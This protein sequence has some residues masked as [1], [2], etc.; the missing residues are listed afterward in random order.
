MIFSSVAFSVLWP[1]AN[2]ALFLARWFPVV[3]VF[4]VKGM[5][6]KALRFLTVDSAPK[7]LLAGYGLYMVGIAADMHTAFMVKVQ[8]WRN[9]THKQFINNSV[10]SLSGSV[11]AGCSV[12]S[13]SRSFKPEPATGIRLRQNFT[14]HPIKK[15]IKFSSRHLSHFITIAQLVAA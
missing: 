5:P 9:G 3:C 14:K 2:A 4:F 15:G 8:T 7:I 13:I 11:Y 12:A 10:C 1:S 6:V